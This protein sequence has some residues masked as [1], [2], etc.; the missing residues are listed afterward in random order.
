MTIRFGEKFSFHFKRAN[1]KENIE[2]LQ[3]II[4]SILKKNCSVKFVID[5]GDED[6]SSE[7]S[8]QN[9]K[10]KLNQKTFDMFGV[11]KVE[12]IE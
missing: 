3:R 9:L 12:I 10:E 11:D 6:S 4:S 7:I 5:N 2:L 8:E 1:S